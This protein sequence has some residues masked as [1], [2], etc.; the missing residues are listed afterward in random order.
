LGGGKREA[1]EDDGIA[2]IRLPPRNMPA[3]AESATKAHRSSNWFKRGAAQGH[4]RPE[5][6]IT[7]PGGNDE[8]HAS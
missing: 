4:I 7:L 8:D 2:Q 5:K 3:M 6:A 1:S